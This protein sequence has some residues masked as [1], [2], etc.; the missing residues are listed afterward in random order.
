MAAGFDTLKKWFSQQQGG[1]SSYATGLGFQMGRTMEVAPGNLLGAGEIGNMQTSVQAW[2]EMDDGP[3]VWDSELNTTTY[4]LGEGGDIPRPSLDTSINKTGTGCMLN[5]GNGT[6]ETRV[7]LGLASDAAFGST[8]HTFCGWFRTTDATPSGDWTMF[9]KWNFGDSDREYALILR[10]TGV[11]Q[12]L[13]SGNG[14]SSSVIESTGT[15]SDNT[16]H[17]FS[18]GWDPSNEI[19]VTLDETQYTNSTSI[20]ATLNQGPNFRLPS[21]LSNASTSVSYPPNNVYYDGLCLFN[22]YLSTAN[23]AWVRNGGDGRTYQNLVDGD[24]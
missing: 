1:I 16:W 9:S 23:I 20:P 4:D 22:E 5:P 14:V 7:T 6:V 17:F 24:A 15:L 21:L 19:Q 12:W 8:A 13:V 3:T 10:S 11:L 18:C 2:W